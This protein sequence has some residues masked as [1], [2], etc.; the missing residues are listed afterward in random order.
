MRNRTEV[1]LITALPIV[2]FVKLKAELYH[3]EYTKMNGIAVQ[4]ILASAIQDA[5]G[6]TV[7]ILGSR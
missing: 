2:H 6:K 7:T 5:A 4:L 3:V 1:V